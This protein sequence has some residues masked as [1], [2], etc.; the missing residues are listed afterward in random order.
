MRKAFQADQPL[1][2]GFAA[3]AE[4]QALSDLFAGAMGYFRN[5][6]GHRSVDFQPAEAARVILFASQ[7]LALVDERV[8][9]A[10]VAAVTQ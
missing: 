7:L 6:T 3:D 5:S 4:R 9:A 2:N 8:A 10:P 1:G